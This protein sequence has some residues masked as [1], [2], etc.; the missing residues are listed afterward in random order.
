MAVSGEVLG[1]VASGGHG[2][3]W[4]R[5]PARAGSGGRPLHA[6]D[7][8]PPAHAPLT[9]DARGSTGL[10]TTTYRAAGWRRGAA[11][12]SA[13][14]HR[15]SAYGAGW[16]I[17]AEHLAAYLAGRERGDTETRWHELVPAYQDL[18][19]NIG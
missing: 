16:Q 2:C 9:A 11:Y 6:R 5:F 4:G 18:A 7:N 1:S 10:P 19:D 17:H 3:S 15:G 8:G 14:W 12:G 13:G